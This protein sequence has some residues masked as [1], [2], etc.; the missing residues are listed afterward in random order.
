[1]YFI[2]K[3]EYRN[4][5]KFTVVNFVFFLSLSNFIGDPF[6]LP[7]NVIYF[8]TGV[9]AIRV[10]LSRPHRDGCDCGSRYSEGGN[11]HLRAE[12]GGK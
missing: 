11:A 9:A 12:Q 3:I 4:N 10:Q 5:F 1:M 8:P 2:I 6:F 7:L